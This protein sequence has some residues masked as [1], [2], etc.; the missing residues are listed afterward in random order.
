M[1]I[2]QANNTFIYHLGWRSRHPDAVLRRPKSEGKLCVGGMFLLLQW[3][4]GFYYATIFLHVFFWM[5]SFCFACFHLPFA[6][7][8]LAAI[9]TTLIQWHE[10]CRLCKNN[11][12][13]FLSSVFA[14]SLNPHCFLI[15]QPRSFNIVHPD[16]FNLKWSLNLAH[17]DI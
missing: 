11:N 16:S 17:T 13:C 7:F 6:T 14:K 2:H 5:F 4:L 10:T 8:C 1:H 15:W 12:V 9:A 3:G